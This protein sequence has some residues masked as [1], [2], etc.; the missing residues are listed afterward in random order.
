MS[1][2]VRE[3]I[4][5]IYEMPPERNKYNAQRPAAIAYATTSLIS[6][7]Y[8]LFK[9]RLIKESASTSMPTRFECK[10]TSYN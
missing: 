8:L 4:S 7:H 1:L 2:I 3:Y 5:D 6:E 9:V 10:S